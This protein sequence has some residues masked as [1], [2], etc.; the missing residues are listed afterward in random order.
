MYWSPTFGVLYT[1]MLFAFTLFFLLSLFGLT[2]QP[3]SIAVIKLN[4]QKLVFIKSYRLKSVLENKGLL[5]KQL[6]LN[7]S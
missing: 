6:D 1:C 2:F 7:E 4:G 5:N 3:N